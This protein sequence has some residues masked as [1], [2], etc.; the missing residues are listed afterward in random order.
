ML[1]NVYQHTKVEIL[2][3]CF[4][5][6]YTFIYYHYLAMSV[7]SSETPGSCGTKALPLK[8]SI[9][10]SSLATIAQWDLKSILKHRDETFSEMMYCV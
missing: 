9:S 7:Q 6:R 1:I 3:T 4:Q 10:V 2:C 8:Y 5:V